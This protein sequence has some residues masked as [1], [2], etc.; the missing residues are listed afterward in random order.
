MTIKDNRSQEFETSI[1]SKN[2]RG[3][4]IDYDNQFIVFDDVGSYEIELS[5]ADK[6][7]MAFMKNRSKINELGKN[8]AKVDGVIEKAFPTAFGVLGFILSPIESLSKKQDRKLARDMK[9]KTLWKLYAMPS[10]NVDFK[11]LSES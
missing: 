6:A 10:K 9:K 5:A 1:L 2:L 11:I 4:T 3:L 7:G 8:Q